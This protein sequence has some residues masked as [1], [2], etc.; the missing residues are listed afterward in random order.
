LP[1]GAGI[2]YYQ[3]ERDQVFWRDV[4]DTC[5]MAIRMNLA[6]AVFQSDRILSVVPPRS[7]RTTNLQFA[8]FI[9]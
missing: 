8:L 7:T 9:I 6:K 3:I 4:A 2:V 1:A 5:S